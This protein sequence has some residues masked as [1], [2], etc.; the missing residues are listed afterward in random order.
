M[1]QAPKQD[2]EGIVSGQGML[3]I[4]RQVTLDSRRGAKV[5]VVTAP[6]SV[7]DSL[8]GQIRDRLPRVLTPTTALLTPTVAFA[9]QTLSD[10]RERTRVSDDYVERLLKDLL[11]GLI[12]DALPAPI[13]PNDGGDHFAR[14][15]AFLAAR[16]TDADL[17]SE[18][19]AGA[20]HISKRQLER[21]FAKHTTTIRA[22]L[23][24]MR[25]ERAVEILREPGHARRLT[26]VQLAH[27]VGFR[28]AS[29]LTRAMNQHGLESPAVIRGGGM[30]S[31]D[32][33]RVRHA[34]RVLRRKS[35]AERV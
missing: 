30:E 22:E 7:A 32:T 2:A 26:V 20:L 5:L 28:S 35:D 33:E 8:S 29:A 13:D 24:R 16:Y 18:H 15:M 9:Q 19:V 1:R 21:A 25:V 17:T 10:C 11:Q 27:R 12:V 34:S 4:G 14:A 6:T 3:V 23:Q 31:H